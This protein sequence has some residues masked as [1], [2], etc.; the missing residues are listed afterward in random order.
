VG[1]VETLQLRNKYWTCGL[2]AAFYTKIWLCS[3]SNTLTFGCVLATPTLQADGSDVPPERLICSR[4]SKRRLK[5]PHVGTSGLLCVK[6]KLCVHFKDLYKVTQRGGDLFKARPLI[7]LTVLKIS[8]T[9]YNF[10]GKAFS[11]WAHSIDPEMSVV[12]MFL[13]AYSLDSFIFRW[14]K[15]FHRAWS[16]SF[17]NPEFSD[18]SET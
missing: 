10:G 3:H 13:Q 5:L 11:S 7:Q 6:V 16:D 18:V 17:A 12:K 14:R 15:Q 8:N 1:Q 4:S 2:C 9:V